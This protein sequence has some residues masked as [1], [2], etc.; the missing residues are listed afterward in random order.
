MRMRAAL[1]CAVSLFAPATQETH[2]KT[3]HQDSFFVAGYTARTNNAAEAGGHGKIGPLWQRWFAEDL[4]AKIPSRVG[5]DILAVYSDY[6][7][8][9]NGDY[10]YLLGVHVSSV[11]N[12]PQG[13]SYRKIAAGRYAIFTT[14]TGP[15]MRVV[16]A[17]WQ[18]IWAAP[19][20]EMGGK[21]A[22][23]TDFEVY[24]ERAADP[25]HAQI[26]IHI[27]VQADQSR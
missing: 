3:E 11:E 8:D 26:E 23:L 24:G 27:G 5:N 19:A 6:A 22:F 15:A 25:Q 16:P 13:L 10:T 7:N 1:L 18:K 21:R 12:L 2:L 9:E 4:G 17:A 14:E 20:S